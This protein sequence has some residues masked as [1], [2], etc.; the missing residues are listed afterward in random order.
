MYEISTRAV[1]TGTPEAA[2]S[3][4]TDVAAWSAWNS[5]ERASRLDG[6]FAAGTHGWSAPRGG[7]SAAWIITHADAPTSWSSRTALPGG[8]LTE[9][10]TFTAT[11]D[12]LLLCTDT[13][14]VTGPLELLF[15]LWFGPRLRRDMAVT[16]R[17]LEAEMARRADP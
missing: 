4:Q 10:R 14:R 3:V 6:P 12:G 9:A 1:I 11:P 7:P 8:A 5:H 16:F 13:M 17:E 15:R 2:W